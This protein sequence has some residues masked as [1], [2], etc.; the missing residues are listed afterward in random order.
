MIIHEQLILKLADGPSRSAA[1]VNLSIARVKKS[2][3][4]ATTVLQL[5]HAEESGWTM[6]EVSNP[7]TRAPVVELFKK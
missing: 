6:L 1:I 4:W 5:L 7:K 3:T 2:G